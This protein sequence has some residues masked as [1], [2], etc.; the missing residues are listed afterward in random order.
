MLFTQGCSDNGSSLVGKVYTYSD[1]LITLTAGFDKDS[2]FYVVKDSVRILSHKSKY[3]IQRINDSTFIAELEIKPQ[4]W[5]KNTWEFVIDKD[6]GIYSTE[7]KKYYKLA[8]DK[9]R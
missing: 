1:S 5:E 2:L 6:R 4:F 8:E 7:S 9:V 3:K